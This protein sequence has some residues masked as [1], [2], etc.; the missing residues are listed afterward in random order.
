MKHEPK[1]IYCPICKRRTGMWD[2]KSTTNII[3]TR[4]EKCWKRVI[5]YTDSKEIKVAPVPKRSTSSGM[6]FL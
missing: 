1:I 3:V 4:C 6:T 2:G 5:Y